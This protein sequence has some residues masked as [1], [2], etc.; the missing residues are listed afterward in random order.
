MGY[1]TNGLTFN[2]LQSAN[3][4]RLPRFKNNL[5]E[6]AHSKEDGSDWTPGEWVCAVTGELGELANLIKKV[7]R[8]DFTLAEAKADIADELADVVIYLDILASQLGI[9]LGEATMRKWNET[10]RK[11]DCNLYIDAEDWHYLEA[12]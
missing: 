12:E 10:S 4:K 1:L 7:R 5:G 2:T 6:P 11:V 8:G 9:S 3:M